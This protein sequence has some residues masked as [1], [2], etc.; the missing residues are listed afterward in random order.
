[1]RGWTTTALVM[2]AIAAAAPAGAAEKLLSLDPAATK[3]TFTL[4]AT[5]HD[6]EGALSL[7]SGE[8]RFD[9]AGGAASG[10]IVVQ[11]AGAKTGNDKR[12][13]QMHEDVLETPKFPVATFRA[14][15]LTG[16][17]HESGASKVALEGVLNFHGADH[18][19]T[20]QA[21]V[22]VQ[23]DRLTAELEVPIPFVEWG[24]EDPSIFILR[25][26]KVVAVHV[27]AEGTLRDAA[28]VAEQ[29]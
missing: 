29:R 7:R 6:V 16:A 23:G 20:L 18:P 4:D 28:P 2:A 21:N 3:V 12:D 8:V 26:A 11:L 15:R 24:L 27:K 17:F 10:A 5:G 19:V 1:M 22:A 25:V 9:P 14:Q 13:R